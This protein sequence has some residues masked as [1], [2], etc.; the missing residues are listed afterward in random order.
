MI[1][2]F[3]DSYASGADRPVGRLCSDAPP[4]APR[5]LTRLP[6]SASYSTTLPAEEAVAA[7][8]ALLGG[9]R[10]RLR[11]PGTEDKTPRKTGNWVSAEKGYLRE[12][13]NLLFHLALLGVLASIALGGLFGYKADK[14]VVE[15]GQF[16][17]TTSQLDEFHPGRLVTGSDL[18]P[19]SIKLDKFSASYYTSG[20]RPASRPR[21]TPG[22]CTPPRLARPPGP[23]TC[24][25]TTR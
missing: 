8:A 6:H 11:R 7:A 24:G 18:A 3:A 25:S 5:N 2:N 4:R 22:S 20:R 21:S 13:G 17:D 12:A 14:L 1:D 19:F 16:S 15:G 23:T 9:K 10:F